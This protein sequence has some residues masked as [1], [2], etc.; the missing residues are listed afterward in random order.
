MPSGV[1]PAVV[2]DPGNAALLAAKI[3]ALSDPALRA[4]VAALQEA[5][6]ARILADDKELN[7]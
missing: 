1:A 5:A 6:R 4:K 3:L 7:P 2:L